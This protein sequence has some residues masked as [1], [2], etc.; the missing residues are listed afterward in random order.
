MS[1]K[2]T[3]LFPPQAICWT[4]V[5]CCAN[6]RSK[7]R[8][9]TIPFIIVKLILT[10]IIPERIGKLVILYEH[11]ICSILFDGHLPNA[12]QKP[13]A[14]IHPIPYHGHTLCG[15]H[16]NSGK[17]NK[18]FYMISLHFPEDLHEKTDWSINPCYFPDSRSSH[19]ANQ[20]LFLAFVKDRASAFVAFCALVTSSDRNLVDLLSQNFDVFS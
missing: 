9:Q 18:P 15:C 11:V 10:Q 3:Y 2:I 1:S 20:N 17:Y 8:K 12:L 5:N 14:V 4:S 16:N 19:L 6:V 7:Y 13:Q